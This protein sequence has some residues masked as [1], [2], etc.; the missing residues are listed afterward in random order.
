M[1]LFFFVAALAVLTVLAYALVPPA[2][3]WIRWERGLGW[4]WSPPNA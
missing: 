2:E 4:S 1:I 3:R